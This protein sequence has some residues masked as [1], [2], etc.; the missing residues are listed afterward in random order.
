MH[1]DDGRIQETNSGPLY[2]VI[3]ITVCEHG[4]EILHAFSRS[5]VVIILQS[6]LDRPHVHRV[7]DDFIIVL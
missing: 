7:L 2:L 4:V 6:L 1:T 5:P 3:D